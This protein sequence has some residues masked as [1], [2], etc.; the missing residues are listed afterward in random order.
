[1]TGGGGGGGEVHW[2]QF[3]A[4]LRSYLSQVSGVKCLDSFNIVKQYVQHE[5]IYKYT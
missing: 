3:N 2:Q 1:M 5:R 4:Y